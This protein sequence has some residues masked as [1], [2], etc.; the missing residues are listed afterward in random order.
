MSEKYPLQETLSPIN[1]DGRNRINE[2]WQRIMAYFDT[3]QQQIK[4]LAG[5]T[6]VDEL[7]Q[8]IEDAITNAYTAVELAISENNAATQE[9]INNVNESLQQLAQAIIE[10]NT[11]I[12]AT[13]EATIEANA[14]AQTANEKV[15][16]AAQIIE[17]LTLLKDQLEQMQTVL[18]QVT[19]AAQTAT[20]NAIDATENANDATANANQ[21]TQAIDAKLNEVDT[22]ILNA[23]D[24]ATEATQAA[25]NIKGWGT[26][27]VWDAVTNFE[28]NNVVTENGSTWQAKRQNT[29]SRPSMDNQDWI[30]LARR[31][32]DG[33]G[34]VSSVNGQSPDENGNVELELQQD[35]VQK[36]NGKSP[37]ATGGVTLDA[38]DVGAYTKGETETHIQNLKDLLAESGYA[39]SD[40][41]NITETEYS[42][43]AISGQFY[44]T[45]DNTAFLPTQEPYFGS[46]YLNEN[47]VN[48]LKLLEVVKISSGITYTRVITHDGTTNTADTGW[49]EGGGGSSGSGGGIT[50]VNPMKLT[51][52][53]ENQKSWNIPNGNYDPSTDS[54]LV[55]HNGVYLPTLSWSVTG[56]APNY[57]LNIPDNPMVAITDN[58]VSI[59]IFSNM[60]FG[61]T[62][63]ITGTRITPLTIG[64]DRLEQSVQDLINSGGAEIANNLTTD[65]PT[66]TLS[67]A[68]GVEI[69]RQLDAIPT[70]Y[71]SSSLTLDDETKAAT[72]KA[73]KQLNDEKLNLTGGTMSGDLIID[74]GNATLS[75]TGTSISTGRKTS[76]IRARV[77]S[78]NNQVGME[79][80]VDGNASFRI[81][82][83]KDVQ[84]L[85][86]NGE[87]SSLQSLKTS[88]VNGKTS[89]AAAITTKGV[90]TAAN[91]TFDTMAT[92]IG[93]IST[94]KKFV[95]GT[96]VATP[97]GFTSEYAN[98]TA[99]GTHP[100]VNLTLPFSPSL[101]F[102]TAFGSTISQ[103]IFSNTS[104]GLFTGTAK[105]SRF[106]T[107][108]LE[109][110]TKNFKAVATWTAPNTYQL[111]LPV[112][113]SNLTYTYKAYE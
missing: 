43:M 80:L 11:A 77:N 6:E 71:F 90:P 58:N 81:L 34:S 110:T 92:N 63:T 39:A 102:V 88:V 56:V 22:A 12:Q 82:G 48:T 62:E 65:D 59:A 45:A 113:Y 100:N 13:Q 46:V 28:K 111:I 73:V 1:R 35:A 69:K 84:F 33:T 89:I 64:M 52:T 106:Y 2:N 104:D 26:A 37:D 25:E 49:I 96:I 78:S 68:M 97:N 31:G 18:T 101:V 83:E 27:V 72:S 60:P 55:F 70:T 7:L 112:A 30:L 105:L 9:A 61:P 103:T 47:G 5:G 87:W 75:L 20:D 85:D 17:S 53:T 74:K 44:V 8:R 36:V 15:V 94:G 16:E 40:L 3:V 4:V 41:K 42:Q 108:T 54:L 91:A 24:A 99:A 57:V 51:T 10:A 32:V 67:A 66:K 21:A 95:E 109:D 50:N 86:N 79:M 14:A 19:T 38:T 107:S 76:I 23:T 98:G 29:N 93:K